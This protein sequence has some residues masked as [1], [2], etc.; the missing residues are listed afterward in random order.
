MSHI[1]I[2]LPGRP[3]PIGCEG[4]Y[5]LLDSND[6]IVIK[7]NSKPSNVTTLLDMQHDTVAIIS[8]AGAVFMPENEY[9]PDPT[10]MEE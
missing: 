8:R 5:M 4:D 7:R 6:T 1:R 3:D 10:N 2:Y 9:V